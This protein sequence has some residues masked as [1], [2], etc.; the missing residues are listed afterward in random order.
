MCISFK[1]PYVKHTIDSLISKAWPTVLELMPEWSLSSTY[2]FSIRCI[3]AF[4]RSGTLDCA[5]APCSGNNFN[6]KITSKKHKNTKNMPLNRLWK[7][8][9]L[10][11]ES[12]NKKLEG[13][14]VQPQEQEHQESQIFHRFEHVRNDCG[15]T[16]S[17]D[18]GI[19]M[20]F[21]E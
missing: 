20:S 12:W 18:F 8:C 9:F 11:C 10:Q 4:L 13:G 15:N 5:S 17:I 19:E 7:G 6:S 16:V 1:K 3:T 21:R 2:V 14:H